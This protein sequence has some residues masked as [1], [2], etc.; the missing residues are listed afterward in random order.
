MASCCSWM[1]NLLEQGGTAA[2]SQ[3]LHPPE[4]LLRLMPDFETT[5]WSPAVEISPCNC[6][7]CT[8]AFPFTPW[9]LVQQSTAEDLSLEGGIRIIAP[10]EGKGWVLS[11]GTSEGRLPIKEFWLTLRRW[12][13]VPP[14]LPL[15]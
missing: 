15:P 14:L 2:G 6:N 12:D 7:C 4:N 8:W 13:F 3:Q 11:L 10:G 5:P 9:D 1:A